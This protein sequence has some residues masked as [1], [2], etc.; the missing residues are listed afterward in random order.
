MTGSAAGENRYRAAV[1]GC[2]AIGSTIEDDISTATY[3]MGLPYGHAPVYAQLARTEPGRRA[4]SAR[5]WRA[6]FDALSQ[7][8]AE[9]AG[10]AMEKLVDDALQEA[11][12]RLAAPSA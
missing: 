7:G 1:I 8:R 6:L 12:K 4:E 11:L 2:G 5:N 3:R 9:V 10:R